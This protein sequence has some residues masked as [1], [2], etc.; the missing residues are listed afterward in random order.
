M[1]SDLALPHRIDGM[2][3]DRQGNS[4]DVMQFAELLSND[5]YYRVARTA[6]YDV[7]RGFTYDLSTI[8]LGIDHS[9]G[10]GD[11]ILFES[12]LFTEDESVSQWGTRW[13]T[14]DEAVAGHVEVARQL[15][16][17]LWHPVAIHTIYSRQSV[18]QLAPPQKAIT[19]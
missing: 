17:G 18:R 8:W 7:E 10:Y 19:A 2:Y 13:G 5:R 3:K 6:F 4:V 1:S 12:M 14:E 11:P 16:R 9:W 15:S